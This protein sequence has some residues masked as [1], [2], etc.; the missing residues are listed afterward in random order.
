MGNL[1]LVM[2]CKICREIEKALLIVNLRLPIDK[3]INW[4][5]IHSGDP[6]MRLLNHLNPGTDYHLPTTILGNVV[7]LSSSS[8]S[9]NI[10]FIRLLNND[11]LNLY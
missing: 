5:D 11:I 2:G 6:R 9:Y 8:A 10:N 7:L 3:K 4:I 1:Y